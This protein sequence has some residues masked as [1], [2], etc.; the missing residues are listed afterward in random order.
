MPDLRLESEEELAEGGMKTRRVGALKSI[1]KG[2]SVPADCEHGIEERKGEIAMW[3]PVQGRPETT[4][5][6]ELD[7]TILEKRS[8]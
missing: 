6:R 8:R 2:L 7:M 1:D 5:A 3:S 4:D